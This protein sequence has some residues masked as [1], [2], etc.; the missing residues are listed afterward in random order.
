M[1]SR[2][3]LFMTGRSQAVRLP[4]EFRFKGKEVKIRRVGAGVLLEPAAMTARE[5]FA[6]MDALGGGPFM[7]D[8]RSQPETQKR[9]EIE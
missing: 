9:D 1:T 6:E 2:A 8:G 4:R 3:K 5:M 7:P